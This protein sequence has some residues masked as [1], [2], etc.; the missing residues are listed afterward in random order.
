[1]IGH[2]E[3]SSGLCSL[4][5]TILSFERGV[6]PANLHMQK[7]NHR[8][9]GLLNGMLKP[10]NTNTPYTGRYAALNCFGFGG[11]N[12]HAVVEKHH[13]TELKM[14]GSEANLPAEQCLPRLVTFCGRNQAMLDLIVDYMKNNP[15]EL[16][17][18]FLSLLSDVSKTTAFPNR[19]FK[20]MRHRAFL[21]L[22]EEKEGGASVV[23]DSL[24]CNKIKDKVR[25]P[26]CFVF[27]GMGS[28]WT[29]MGAQL[30]VFPVVKAALEKCSATLKTLNPSFDLMHLLTADDDELLKSPLNS[31]VAIAAIQIAVVDLLA[32]LDITAEYI[33]GHSIGEL[34]CAYADG[35]LTAEETIAAA[36]WRG[37]CIEQA[38][39]G[40][41]MAAVACSWQEAQEWCTSLAGG[42]VWPA[43]HNGEDSV[44]V[45]GKAE[46][47]EAFIE[48][49]QTEKEGVFARQ[50]NSSGVAFH[51]PLVEG[52]RGDLL[53]RL[54]K[55]LGGKPTRERS[56]RW[57]SSTYEQEKEEK[58][59]SL[60]DAK[61][62]V[63]NLILPVR[64]H[65][66]LQQVPSSAVFLEIGPHH[67][68]QAI[69]KRTL[70][71]SGS[72]VKYVASLSR[73]GDNPRSLLT[74]LGGLY[75]CGL[76]PSIERLYPKVLYP[77]PRTT[78]SLHSLFKWRHDRSFTVTQYPKFFNQTKLYESA[79]TVDTTVG[80]EK[81]L[82]DHCIDSRVLFPATGYLFLAWTHV[83]KLLNVD[84][85]ELPVVFEDVNL[86]RATIIPKIGFTNFDVYFIENTGLFTITEGGMLTT[87]G[88]IR[89]VL[90]KERSSMLQHQSLLKSIKEL[91]GQS[92]Q[93]EMKTKDIYKEFRLRGYDYGPEFQAVTHIRQVDKTLTARVIF[94]NWITYVDGLIQL[95]VLGQKTRGLFLPVRFNML[96]CDPKLLFGDV[97][98]NAEAGF[99]SG[100]EEN[101]A[102]VV[103]VFD[104]IYDGVLNIGVAPGIEYQGIKANLAPRK[105]NQKPVE[106]TFEFVAHDELDLPYIASRAVSEK[107]VQLMTDQLKCYQDMCTGLLTDRAK[108]PEEQL[109]AFLD[110]YEKVVAAAPVLLKLAETLAEGSDLKAIESLEQDLLF[111]TYL[112]ERFMRSQ[113]ETFTDN[114]TEPSVQVLE[115]NQTPT[116]LANS[117]LNWLLLS[118][119]KV[120]FT[121]GLLH[122]GLNKFA[123]NL[124]STHSQHEWLAEKSKFP[125][126][127]VNIG[128]IVYKDASTCPLLALHKVNFDSLLDSM[129][130]ALQERGFAL[131]ILRDR[132]FDVEKKL[133]VLLKKTDNCLIEEGTSRVA[134]F[135][136][137]IEKSPLQVVSHKSDVF[138]VHVYMVRKI[139]VEIAVDEQIF[140][141]VDSSIS[142][143]FTDLQEKIRE[144]CKVEEANGA[145]GDTGD[146][147]VS[148]TTVATTTVTT[149]TTSAN[150]NRSK[151]IWLLANDANSGVIGFIS[152][153]HKE[154]LGTRV[155]CILNTDT[156]GTP[157]IDL[158]SATVQ[159]II[160]QDLFM[161]TLGPKGV[162]GGYKH[163]TLPLEDY[164][165][166]PTEHCYIN[167]STRGDLSSLKWFE[168]QHK[169]WPVNSR[170]NQILC[171]VYY[172]AL[173]FRDIMLATGKLPPDALPAEIGLD[174]CVLGLE[175]AGRDQNGN[176]VMGMLAA[177]GL[178]TTLIMEHQNFLWPVPPHWSMEEAATVPVAYA[179]AYY[180]LLIRG[181]MQPGE[182]VLIHS[183]S[184][185]VGQ[186]AIAIA[187][188]MN[189][190][191]FITV[192]SDEKRDILMQIFPSLKANQ[193]ASS[194]S[195]E[196]SRKILQETNGRGVDLVLNS[197]AEEKLQESVN[198]LAEFGRFL[199]IGKYDLSQNT[200]LGKSGFLLFRCLNIKNV[201][202]FSF[203]ICPRLWQ[204]RPSTAFCWTTC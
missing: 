107:R 60:L 58:S 35:C 5:K 23:S 138:G 95:A 124:D 188:D 12:V 38:A 75:A 34:T 79:R 151:N 96:R 15:K 201:S 32:S 204:T 154:P 64:F 179:T 18:A 145:P 198:C 16:T 166:R 44:T 186:A 110:K 51:S 54:T 105:V 177:K 178:A 112:T 153:L 28:Q 121:Y 2:T 104:A 197:L 41:A 184:G 152:C 168:S 93:M 127:L 195:I 118:S 129:W 148:T 136:A 90:G 142:T 117:I 134:E 139:A 9:E 49:L 82:T 137:A 26:V 63:E 128:L 39:S 103:R 71:G 200:D 123:L 180:A 31:F 85:R 89:V 120:T 106:E 8:I 98:G 40:G 157:A 109:A 69:I 76:N 133:A 10:V 191:L 116:I 45:A 119:F 193:F 125:T 100:A 66:A 74:M 174:D 182:S 149:T 48:K 86:H 167:A 161:N 185:A 194:R 43:C 115:V 135:E 57:I 59:S 190:R 1:M 68:L 183:G 181:K 88:K 160:K 37:V 170:P 61:Y 42:K 3:A 17:P 4:V 111:R 171:H 25:P 33:V 70:M 162:P 199:E 156:E 196:F 80:E 173:N 144:I 21:M 102:P 150:N 141:N 36:Y 55:V 50:V 108:L 84:Y 159:K 163:F 22:Q 114:L 65:S 94:K 83:A 130:N 97:A 29:A 158:Q 11:V 62:L 53:G 73:Q 52:I 189:C 7:P 24:H 187:V 131:I 14:E 132:P 165:P 192:G 202:C 203:Q 169:H 175:F 81:F 19:S 77:V 172:S 147:D 113:L 67:L 47:V 146:T 126:D 27:T 99:G 20:G 155:R 56:A 164:E 6:I 46:D 72:P 176:R 30:A 143:W 140:M 78:A 91:Q 87:S 13:D 101:G 92:C 122:S